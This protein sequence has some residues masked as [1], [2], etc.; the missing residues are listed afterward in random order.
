MPP[1][2]RVYAALAIVRSPVELDNRSAPRRAY[3]AAPEQSRIYS[4]LGEAFMGAP[5]L[6]L[7]PG[8]TMGVMA[9]VAAG[10]WLNAARASFSRTD[11]AGLTR[12][13]GSVL[14]WKRGG[15]PLPAPPCYAACRAHIPGFGAPR[16][17]SRRG[18]LVAVARARA[19]PWAA[20]AGLAG[21][22]RSL[23]VWV[24]ERAHP[25]AAVRQHWKER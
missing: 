1:Y 21:S 24:A 23:S 19:A 14:R 20:E 4:Q 9:R 18:L 22:M 11:L 7:L 25:G 6:A 2:A 12:S 15:E 13:P 10:K 17:P 3:L 8:P 5:E 16:T